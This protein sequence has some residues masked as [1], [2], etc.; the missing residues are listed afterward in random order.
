MHLVS[1]PA[2]NAPIEGTN[3]NPIRFKPEHESP[4]R[5]GQPF[6]QLSEEEKKGAW[7]IDES[8]KYIGGKRFWKVVAY[9]PVSKKFLE[10]AGEG[11]SSQYAQLYAVYMAIKQHTFGRCHMYTDSWSVAQGLATWLPTWVV[12][13]WKIY[14]K[15]VW[16][17]E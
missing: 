4:D 17:K 2:A 12:K 5:W 9:N 13:N 10:T 6:G 1:S 8:A 11:K 7:L 16:G 15:E 14:A 3:H